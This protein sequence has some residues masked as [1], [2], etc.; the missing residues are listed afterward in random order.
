VLRLPV[1]WIAEGSGVPVATI[2]N[3][4]RLARDVLRAALRRRRAALRSR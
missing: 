4:V 1:K 2:Y 3:R